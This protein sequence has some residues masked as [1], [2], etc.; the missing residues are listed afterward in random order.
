MLKSGTISFRYNYAINGRQETLVLGRYGPDG[1][2]LGIG[3][4]LC[5]ITIFGKKPPP[6]PATVPEP[7]DRGHQYFAP[8]ILCD[9]HILCNVGQEPRDNDR[10]PNSGTSGKTQA[11]LEQICVDINIREIQVCYAIVKAKGRKG[12]DLNREVEMC[13][14]EANKRMFACFETAKKLTDN[15]AHPA[16]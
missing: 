10:G 11:E 13:K 8:Q 5:S 16:P 4:L 1:I 14:Q 9:W 3:G 7:V 15:G 6:L 12:Q 2:K